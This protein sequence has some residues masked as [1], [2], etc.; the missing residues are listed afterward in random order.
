MKKITQL[1]VTFAFA[2]VA[3]FSATT[4][5]E[6]SVVGQHYQVEAAN[7]TI[8]GSKEVNSTAKNSEASKITSKLFTAA[9]IFSGFVL[10]ISIIMIIVGGLRYIL[11]NGDQRQAE[12]GKM[13]LIYSGIGIV[14]ALSAFVIARLFASFKF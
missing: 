14:I 11:A 6:V 2:L 1:F 9:N 10:A 7:S 8:F 5:A 3:V 13:I 12:T 4:V